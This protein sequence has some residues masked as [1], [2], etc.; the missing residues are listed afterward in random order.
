M[1]VHTSGSVF[2]WTLLTL[3]P[4]ARTA[5][6]TEL[7]LVSKILKKTMETLTEALNAMVQII[8]DERKVA[9]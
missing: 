3:F 7:F 5:L 2:P 8:T 1:A 9:L 4:T 6:Q